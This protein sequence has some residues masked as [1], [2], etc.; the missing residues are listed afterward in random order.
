[1]ESQNNSAMIDPA[2]F[3]Y[4]KTHG[5]EEIEVSENLSRIVSAL[6]RHVAVS[7]GHLSRI[8][9]TPSSQRENPI[10]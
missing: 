9:A 10:A 8:H 2:I 3:A 4:L 1:M 5:E 7:Q 6:H